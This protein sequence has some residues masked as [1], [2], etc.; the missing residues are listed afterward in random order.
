MEQKSILNRYREA[1]SEEILTK[2]VIPLLA[3]FFA[4]VMHTFWGSMYV[5]PTN[6]IAKTSGSP[7]G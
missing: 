3:E 6:N 7:N 2:I 5:I 1:S 4:M